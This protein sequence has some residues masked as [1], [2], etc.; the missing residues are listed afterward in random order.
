MARSPV[1][2]EDDRRIGAA[3]DAVVFDVVRTVADRRPGIAGEFE[4][5]GARV[6]AQAD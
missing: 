2:I 6:G 4:S 3:A 5:V 1:T